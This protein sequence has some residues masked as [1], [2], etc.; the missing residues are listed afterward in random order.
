M[1]INKSERRQVSCRSERS[2][3]EI[4]DEGF[5]ERA[6]SLPAIMQA[7]VLG[8]TGFIGSHIARAL[9]NEGIDV[10][11]LRRDSSPTL[12]LEGLKVEQVTGDLNDP[13][14][15]LKAMQGCEALFNTAGY[16]PLYSFEKE[17]QKNIAIQ[18]TRNVINAALKTP[19]L[20]KFVYTSSM[21][22]MGKNPNGFSDEKTPYDPHHFKGLYY[23]IKILI[24]QEL[25]QACQKGLPV[26]MVNPTAVFGDYDVKP[27]SGAL[28]VQLVKGK[29]PAIVD[30]KMN[31][32]DA[33]DV[34]R[35]QVAALKKGKIGERYI[36][37][38]RNTTT[39]ELT[40]MIAR[41]AKVSGPKFKIPLALT[42][43]GAIVSEFL[44]KYV[45]HQDKPFLPLVG[46]DFLKYGMHYDTSKA[47]TELGFTSVPLEETI[48]RALSWFRENK[49]I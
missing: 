25:L 22:T 32:V 17:K 16:Y 11:I 37:G 48:D 40:Q 27:T 29:V 5:G 2:V 43:A 41:L 33:R 49:Y 9:V 20:K 34:G 15:L 46:I 8:A 1:H 39:W 18:Q 44:G 3:Q 31:T 23:E 21:S 6:V 7:I 30:A 12:A 10:R 13:D 35:G 38:S 19:T 26:V 42:E 45:L 4:I 47:K 24:E 14:S 28:I 36:L